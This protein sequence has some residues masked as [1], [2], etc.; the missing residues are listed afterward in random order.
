MKKAFF[1]FF[2]LLIVAFIIKEIQTPDNP[3][4]P[5][6]KKGIILAFGD[7]LTYGYGAQMGQSYPS[8]L[9]RLTGRTVINTGIP[10]ELS[11]EG[12]KRLPVLLAKYRPKLLLLC[13]GGNDILRNH[14][15][16]V[17]KTNLQTMI[18]TAR[19][20]N[21]DV[22]LIGVPEFS[23]V[24]LSAH[25]VYE[26]IAQENGLP[27]ENDALAEII[28]DNRYKSDQIHPNA[29]GYALIA[30]AVEKKLREIYSFEE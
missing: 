11:A 5:F 25:P 1:A 20:Q 6:P 8:E 3:L 13:H 15:S 12:T 22:L 29:Q 30:K 7:S 19:G 24:Y 17:L 14:D 18:N 4:K 28:S 10:G 27:I 23:L 21:I 2:T 9:E 26:E 16:Q